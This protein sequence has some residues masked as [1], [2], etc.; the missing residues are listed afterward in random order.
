MAKKTKTFKPSRMTDSTP[1]GSIEQLLS[2]IK[3]LKQEK[4]DIEFDIFDDEDV[5]DSVLFQLDQ[6]DDQIHFLEEEINKLNKI[7]K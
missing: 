1:T 4:E 7:K 2:Q 5:S 3:V 6:I